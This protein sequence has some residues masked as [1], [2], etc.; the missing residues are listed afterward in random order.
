MKVL[1]INSLYR[2][3]ELGGAE[4]SVEALASGL[5]SKGI[6]PVIVSTAETDSVDMVDGIRCYYLKISNLY[7]GRNA[8]SQPVYKK[9]FWHLLDSYNLSTVSKLSRVIEIEQP[10]LVH[11]NNL[12]GFSVSA[13]NTVKSFKLPIVHTIRDHYLICPNAVMYRNDR[14]C[15]KQCTRCRVYA[16][17]RKIL[18]SGVDAV[19]GV[20][21]FILGKHLKAGY[22]KNSK[23]KTHVYSS[24]PDGSIRR[25]PKLDNDL[26]TFGFVGMLAPIKGIEYLLQRFKKA[27]IK[28]AKLYVFGSGITNDYELYL[29]GKYESE[30]IR[31]MGRQKP[32]GIYADIDV[33]I[34][35][36]LCDDAFPR[37]LVE[38]YYNGIPVIATCRGGA[39]EMVEDGK[40]G[41]VFDPSIE[42]D[43]ETKIGLFAKDRDVPSRMKEECLAAAGEFE[44]GKATDKVIRVYDELLRKKINMGSE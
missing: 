7:W 9:P 44:I 40:T 19:I 24:M 20:S 21:A 11:S 27:D 42:N 31:F 5:K 37:V 13:W 26:L 4:R 8:K 12:A 33:V 23:I 35:P 32:E 39:P 3:N 38:S 22:F 34:I 30:N 14:R 43:L 10:D 6:E 2:P 15:E 41:Y 25:N 1:I 18:S 29:K 28:K 36:S 16:V 17:P